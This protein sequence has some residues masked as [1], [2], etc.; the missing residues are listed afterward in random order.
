MGNWSVVVL[1]QSTADF[2]RAVLQIIL[3]FDLERTIYSNTILD[4]FVS[5]LNRLFYFGQQFFGKMQ[6]PLM[7]CFSQL[8]LSLY[9]KFR[10]SY[11]TCSRGGRLRLQLFSILTGCS[12]C[13]GRI[14]SLMGLLAMDRHKRKMPVFGHLSDTKVWR[15][16][17]NLSS[18]GDTAQTVPRLS[19][20]QRC[21]F[22]F[23]IL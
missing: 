9:R 23:C 12:V 19:Q 8:S 18:G 13:S 5:S 17:V 10:V 16:R 20:A 1:N 11:L 22:H 7:N 3:A 21:F 4:S 6:L 14:S 15:L 2:P